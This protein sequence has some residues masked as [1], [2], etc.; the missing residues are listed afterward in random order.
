MTPLWYVTTTTAAIGLVAQILRP[1][2]TLRWLVVIMV[3]AT[4]VSRAAQTPMHATSIRLRLAGMV[5]AITLDVLIRPHA[6]T[7]HGLD[8]IMECVDMYLVVW[9][10]PHVTMILLPPAGH[11][12]ATILAAQIH[13]PVTTI[14]WQAVI[15]AHVVTHTAARIYM[16]ATTIRKLP[17]PCMV[18]V[19]TTT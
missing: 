6:T 17:A 19:S 16:H 18:H 14:H 5:H 11:T 1:V 2:I 13:G 15:T 12:H 8:V 3:L 10:L 9:I 7:I 4:T